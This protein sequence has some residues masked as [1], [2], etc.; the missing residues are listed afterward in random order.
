M[1]EFHH[2]GE[3]IVTMDRVLLVCIIL[4]KYFTRFILETL[5]ISKI[6]QGEIGLAGETVVI[7][8]D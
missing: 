5:L 2:E 4:V 3:N 6:P 7:L 8:I 1:T